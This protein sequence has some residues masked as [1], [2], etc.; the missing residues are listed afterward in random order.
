MF[1]HLKHV[2]FIGCAFHTPYPTCAFIMPYSCIAHMHL[3]HA[4]CQPYHAMFYFMLLHHF[5]LLVSLAC[6]VYF[7]LCSILFLRCFVFC[8]SFNFHS[9][10]TSYA[11]LSLFLSSFLP[12]LLHGLFVYLWQKRRRVSSFLYDSC[13]HSQGEKFYLVHI[14]RGRNSIGEMHILKWRR[15]LLMRKPCFVLFY[16]MFFFCF[17]YGALSYF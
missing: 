12:L 13:A 8:F 1:P 11:S 5:D 17:L 7:I 3:L 10:C 14:C 2:W 15:H 9:S 16:I 4:S 6:H